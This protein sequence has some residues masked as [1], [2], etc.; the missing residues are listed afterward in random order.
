[1]EY[2]F[3]VVGVASLV[4]AGVAIWTSVDN[5]NRT[6]DALSEIRA[7]AGLI[8]GSVTTMQNKL[9]DTVASIANPVESNAQTA[10]MQA[11]MPG[12][13]QNPDQLRTF[14]DFA[15]ELEREGQNSRGD[16][17]DSDQSRWWRNHY[18]RFE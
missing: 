17:H 15:K 5:H 16:Y 11:I 7:Q 14:M 6:K 12:L 2:V 13:M 10:M 8:S 3:L 1:M 4:L 9:I 18:E